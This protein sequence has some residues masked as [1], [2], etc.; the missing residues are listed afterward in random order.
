MIEKQ[1]ACQPENYPKVESKDRHN[2][3]S[4]SE[5]SD[6]GLE[7]ERKNEPE[8]EI[9]KMI[10][11]EVIGE[12]GEE[13]QVQ[14]DSFPSPKLPPREESK[15]PSL[16]NNNNCIV[17]ELSAKIK[18]EPKQEKSQSES[19][20][21]EAGSRPRNEKSPVPAHAAEHQSHKAHK[22][23]RPRSLNLGMA[24]EF[25]Y[26]K[27]T[28]GQGGNNESD[29]SD[30]ENASAGEED[31]DR[32]RQHERAFRTDTKKK[33]P[34]AMKMNIALNDEDN[35]V[36]AQ[37]AQIRNKDKEIDECK[38]NIT[39]E[40]LMFDELRK[41]GE[42]LTRMMRGEVA[43]HLDHSVRVAHDVG[44]RIDVVSQKEVTKMIMID[45]EDT[46]EADRRNANKVTNDW[47]A[48]ISR[49][50][51]PRSYMFE[52]TQAEKSQKRKSTGSSH[53][54][55]TRIVPLKPERSRSC[56]NRDE[57][58]NIFKPEEERKRLSGNFKREFISFSETAEQ[59]TDINR[60]DIWPSSFAEKPTV[61]SPVLTNPY[62]AGSPKSPT[63]MGH[64]VFQGWEEQVQLRERT[65]GDDFPT[66]MPGGG[67]SRDDPSPFDQ[68]AS[69]AP[70]FSPRAAGLN[71][72]A[73]PT[74]P[75]KTKKARESGLIL[76]NSRYPAK[77]AGVDGAVER[78][79]AVTVLGTPSAYHSFGRK[80]I[81]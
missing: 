78:R 17:A 60:N 7:K 61:S 2:R 30:E 44:G 28:D 57:P 66:R 34:V 16:K 39:Q 48:N 43:S 25:V 19:F 36:T 40:S 45:S 81:A 75:V 59:S 53:V 47:T 21:P 64:N 62:Q 23:K 58:E 70:P 1:D 32:A 65:F 6:V 20:P 3:R 42:N 35:L 67:S 15:E 33:Q 13:M 10:H 31:D 29:V 51:R 55:I 49:R 22:E 54:E 38:S 68:G 27:E 73:P 80:R 79:H 76:R 37:A 14:M 4:L 12:D 50:E 71:K 69:G 74:P 77:E 5:V 41:Q 56:T 26:E 63:M 8:K 52:E 46:E 18:A 11:I 72:N 9:T 24:T